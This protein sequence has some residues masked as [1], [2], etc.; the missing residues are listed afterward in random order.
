MI[1][2]GTVDDQVRQYAGAAHTGWM[3]LPRSR[4]PS[5]GRPTRAGR[6]TGERTTAEAIPRGKMEAAGP[7]SS[8]PG[9]TPRARLVVTD[10]RNCTC[11]SG[12]CCGSRHR[13]VADPGRAAA[14]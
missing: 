6:Q 13:S 8:G 5:S 7:S 2:G 14:L 3:R 9:S 10:E 11:Q 12:P 1:G 4:W